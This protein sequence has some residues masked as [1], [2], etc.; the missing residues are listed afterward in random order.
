MS[1]LEDCQ[2]LAKSKDLKQ[3]AAPIGEKPADDSEKG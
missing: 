2:L 1:A 3:R